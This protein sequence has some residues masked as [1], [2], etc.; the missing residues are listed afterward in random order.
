ML[1]GVFVDS[2]PGG[3]C[4]CECWVRVW[5]AS[6]GTRVRQISSEEHNLLASI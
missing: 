6:N 1:L 3:Q 4:I 2:S 5:D